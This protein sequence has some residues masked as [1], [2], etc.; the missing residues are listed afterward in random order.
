M[1]IFYPKQTRKDKNASL[2]LTKERVVF[3][4]FR[5]DKSLYSIIAICKEC[6]LMQSE[7]GRER[8]IR[9]TMLKSNILIILLSFSLLALVFSLIHGSW[10][11]NEVLDTLEQQTR[12]VAASADNEID[13]MRTMAMNITYS[14]RLQDKVYLRR[15][16][17]GGQSEEAD[18]LSGILSLIVFPNRPIDQIN[19]YTKD[20]MRI[21]SGLRNEVT[22]DDA[23]TRPWYAALGA[24]ETHQLL[25]F[26]GQDE[27]LS[28]YMT[29][30][31]G[32]IFISLVL[33]NY[34]NFGNPYGFI[35][36]RQRVSRILSAMIAHR[37]AFGEKMYFYD[38]EGKRIYPME[39]PEDGFLTAAE[40]EALPNGM[41]S[42]GKGREIC[43]VSCGRGEFRAVTL[44]SG[45]DLMSPVRKQ[46]MTILLITLGTL[47]LTVVSSV[48]LSRRI[49]QP[50]AEICDQI[51]AF[52]IEHPSPLPELHSDIREMQTL[53]GAFSQMQTTL[54]DHVAK[55]LEL[56][57]QEMQSRMLALQAQMNPHFLYNSLQAIQAMSD[58]GMNS[59]IAEMCQ[60]MAAILRYIS[61]D[62][63]QLVPLE[64]EILHTREY[65][66]CME[67]RYQG[68]L[69]YEI[70]LPEALNE[71]QVPKLCVQLL[72]ENAVKFTTEKRPPY[73]IRIEGAVR[74][75]EYELKIMDNGPGFDRETME[76][77]RQQMKGIRRTSTLPTLKING[78]GILHVYIRFFLLYGK[79]FVFRL[80]NNP[81]G[82]ACV[83]IG[84]EWNEPAV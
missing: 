59:E 44:I 43:S 67:I 62:S 71:V 34:D 21:S 70:S 4:L 68:D 36:I 26:S 9:G 39:D 24:D 17:S 83:V 22:K 10:V 69:T 25:F 76:E 33:E 5:E 77:L 46:I 13:Q 51:E 56:Q 28:K 23:G 41:T 3:I 35:E 8:T 42:D 38:R 50:L 75:T 19:L 78:M 16:D 29:D 1:D 37:S 64:K 80:E 32:K 79:K 6:S 30:A 31:Y 72:V 20:G 82:G 48:M 12:A 18:R 74:E 84:G 58:E 66:R 14:T 61:S 57:N 60:S 49:T 63:A 40:L 53:H 55:M 81:E 7:G 65:L 52:D 27:A 45:T 73:R 54:S 47:L 2:R 15:G 11:R